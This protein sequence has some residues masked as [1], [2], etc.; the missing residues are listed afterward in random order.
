MTEY[1]YL[2]DEKYVDLKTWPRREAFEFFRGFDKPY[3]NVCTRLDVTSLLGFVHE[4]KIASVTLA[5]H[6]IAI[7]AGNAVENFRYRLR[8]GR[9]LVHPVIHGGTTVILPNESF[10]FAYFEYVDDFKK[11]ADA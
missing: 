4:T 2:S 5:Y 6:Y 1:F 9:V 3:F 11:F 8:E 10:T 7:R